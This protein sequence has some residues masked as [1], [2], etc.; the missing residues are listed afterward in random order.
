MIHAIAAVGVALLVGFVIGAQVS[1]GV[2]HVAA[3][4]VR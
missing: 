4:L 1:L 2:C 3:S